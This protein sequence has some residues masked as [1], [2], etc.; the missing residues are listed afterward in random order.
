MNILYLTKKNEIFHSEVSESISFT[1]PVFVIFCDDIE[2]LLGLNSYETIFN[3]LPYWKFEIQPHMFTN[4][5]LL[6]SSYTPPQPNFTREVFNIV[7]TDGEFPLEIDWNGNDFRDYYLKSL[8]EEV[9]T[10]SDLTFFPLDEG[11]TEVSMHNYLDDTEVARCV[12]NVT[13]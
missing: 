8:N 3:N 10:V 4:K 5:V 11:T 1:E 9:G 12:V 7:M 2:S 6:N 13:R